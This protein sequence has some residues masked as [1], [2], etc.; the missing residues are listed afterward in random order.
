MKKVSDKQRKRNA[1]IARIKQNKPKTCI[2]CGRYANDLAHLF[3]RSTHPQYY[4]DER[5]LVI[6]CRDCHNLYD[7]NLIFRNAQTNIIEIARTF[8]TE[9]EI[10]RHFRL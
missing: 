4:T 3:P 1:E 5:N 2:F 10:N 6:M 7:S 9:Q 8:A